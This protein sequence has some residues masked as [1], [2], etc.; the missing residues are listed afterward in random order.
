[1]LC[2]NLFVSEIKMN[3]ILELFVKNFTFAPIKKRDKNIHN[4]K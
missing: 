3:G 1:M 2:K 4:F